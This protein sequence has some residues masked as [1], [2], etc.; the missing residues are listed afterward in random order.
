MAYVKLK[1]V[2]RILKLNIICLSS[3]Y[4]YSQEFSVN[5]S[6]KDFD[7]REFLQSATVFAQNPIDSTLISY[8]I[9]DKEGGFDLRILTKLQDIRFLI[10]Y[11]GY[12][13]YEKY[14]SLKTQQINIGTVLMKP[15][16][17]ELNEIEV[18]GEVPPILIK[19]DT[20]E[21]NASSFKTRSDATLEDLLKILPGVEIDDGGIIVV[22]GNIV[23]KILVNG[24]PFF[25]KD[26]KIA[27]K[28][29]PAEIIDK[30]Q[31]VDSKSEKEKFT[32]TKSKNFDKTLNIKI[33]KGKGK[34][35][36]GRIT[37][38]HGDNGKYQV[39]GIVNRFN[40]DQRISVL[41]GSNNID[42][43]G[44]TSNDLSELS[45][46]A[47][48]ISW[49]GNKKG[50]STSSDVGF[51][52]SDKILKNTDL[53]SEYFY[54]DIG[55]EN[56]DRL[57]RKYF[58]PEGDFLSNSVSS[59]NS[60]NSNHRLDFKLNFQIDSTT[61]VS[62]D[63]LIEVNR[64]NEFENIRTVSQDLSGNTLNQSESHA[65]IDGEEMNLQST[66]EV[67]KKLKKKGEFLSVSLNN[68]NLRNNY[69]NNLT[70]VNNTF[71]SSI[72]SNITLHQSV[73]GSLYKKQYG[74]DLEYRK[75]IVSAL[76][77]VP[78][79]NIMQ[80]TL[81]NS[82]NVFEQEEDSNILGNQDSRLSAN[83]KTRFSQY[84]PSLGISYG[85]DK[86]NLDLSLGL[87]LTDLKN[88]EKN[89]DIISN[90]IY[91]DFFYH[92][93]VTYKINSREKVTLVLKS[94]ISLPESNFFMP[95]PNE[96]NPS[97]IIVGN[98]DLKRIY[99]QNLA[100]NYNN[101]NS[102]SKV[103]LFVYG[104]ITL[105]KD[106]LSIVRSTD[107]D[108]IRTTTYR[109]TTG[110]LNANFR[111]SISKT[112]SRDKSSYNYHLGINTRINQQNNISN[113]LEYKVDRLS[114]YPSFRFTYNLNQI[115]NVQASYNP[116]YI[117]T[118]YNSDNFNGINI[119]SH[120]FALNTS[121]Y[122]PKNLVFEN[123]IT[124]NYRPNIGNGFDDSNIFWNMSIGYKVMK[125]KGVF[126]L[127]IFDLL[128]ENINTFR[129]T[130]DDYIQD[131]EN[132]V[133]KRYVL[134]SFTYQFGN[135]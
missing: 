78:K 102:K 19:K 61:K 113:G 56:T 134:L 84:V 97:D 29:L 132:T 81:E 43:P 75:R 15:F 126:R 33:K 59:Q 101:Y 21:F 46:N 133:L 36:F 124:Y 65:I 28:N 115:L 88:N 52:F 96:V 66:L 34:S 2:Y 91:Q 104:D 42:N 45:R 23:K 83:L 37:A 53:I 60:N 100:L 98:I 106:A 82:R 41:G 57:N 14:I 10:S 135:K 108:L 62:I 16:I 71:N 69:V 48:N 54:S 103:G 116:R 13:T 89:R 26:T 38:G 94:D 32:E 25:S 30:I 70:S 77:I 8:T 107:E 64:K 119:L 49:R 11:N 112:Q 72:P 105:L 3:V 117:I 5:G 80:N 44:F 67:I 51:S 122:L 40:E 114:I 79:L 31:L 109:S 87:Y 92:T 121:T 27:I 86:L 76:F 20:L 24:T 47:K 118:K 74:I 120:G 127:R 17:F 6:I 128:N 35:A 39:S 22:N 93:F 125:S 95:V 131:S 12:Q 1:Y 4:T 130:D 99:E 63:P 73:I 85:T 9:S 129:Y 7:N 110:N 55:V 123:D 111:A 58:L 90:Q 18:I 50:V 68:Q